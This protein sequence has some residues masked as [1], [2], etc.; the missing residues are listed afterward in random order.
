MQKVPPQRTA[1]LG[2]CGHLTCTVL[3]AAASRSQLPA[4]PEAAQQAACAAPAVAPGC[5][6]SAVSSPAAPS[7]G[8]DDRAPADQAG[9]SASAT[10]PSY[11]HVVQHHPCICNDTFWYA[12]GSKKAHI[13]KM[14]AGIASAN[15]EGLRQAAL[16]TCNT[17]SATSAS[18]C[19]MCS[20]SNA[21]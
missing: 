9:C 14:Q 5:S 20:L 16:F 11:S 10:E 2:S 18:S 19:S 21:G 13:H 3:R 8:A 12:D 15:C 17:M 6:C 4:D 7:S 1:V